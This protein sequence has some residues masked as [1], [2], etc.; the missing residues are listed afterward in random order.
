MTAL[1]ASGSMWL[2][3]RD[4]PEG[5][6][7]LPLVDDPRGYRSFLL[8]IPPGP[9][10]L[11][12]A[13]DEIEQIYLLDGDFFDDEN[14]YAAGDFVLRMPGAMHRAGSR[15]GCTMLI[16]YTPLVESRP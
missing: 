10:G 1:P 13:H 11:L 8:K 2:A 14:S 7:T 6:D 3:A 9:L 15:G 4:W 16:V 12:H 5:S